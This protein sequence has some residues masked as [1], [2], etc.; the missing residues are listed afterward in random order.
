M[1][2]NQNTWLC[3]RLGGLFLRSWQKSGNNINSMIVLMMKALQS[4]VENVFFF[5][6]LAE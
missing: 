2:V 3:Y 6:L 4:Q 5:Y 1:R